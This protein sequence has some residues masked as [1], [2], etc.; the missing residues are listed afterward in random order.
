LGAGTGTGTG[1][2]SVL[3]APVPFVPALTRA[4]TTCLKCTRSGKLC[5]QHD[6]VVGVTPRTKTAGI[7]RNVTSMS[8]SALHTK[9]NAN[10][11][12]NVNVNVKPFPARTKAGGLCKKCEAKGSFCHLHL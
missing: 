3:V 7:V 6:V 4:G 8:A 2:G 10:V 11:N 5:A 9:A 1:L 12:V